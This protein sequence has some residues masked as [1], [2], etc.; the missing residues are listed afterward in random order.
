M[1]MEKLS[2][3]IE[4][5]LDNV[6]PGLTLSIDERV[7]NTL[8]EVEDAFEFSE[9]KYQLIEG[10][11]YDY[12]FNKSSF[13]FKENPVIQPF[14]RKK[15]LGRI[16]PNTYVGTL[17]LEIIEEG[18]GKS[19]PLQ[20]EVR[21]RK[22]DYRSD[23][24]FMLESITEKCTDLLLQSNN[25]ISQTFDIDH[26]TDYSTLYQ[27]YSFLRSVIDSEDFDEA[28]NRIINFPVTSWE[29]NEELID[30][31]RLR[32]IN[33]NQIK[34]ISSLPNRISLPDDYSLY[35]A[36]LTTVPTKIYIREKS[37][38]IDTQENRF[39]KNA[40]ETF[41]HACEDIKSLAEE[42]S[43]LK[44]ESEI[45]ILK[46]EEYLQHSFFRNIGR[47]T[48]LKLNS[49][50]LQRK[51]GYREILRTWLMFDLA[52]KLVWKGGEDVYSAGKKDI[53]NLYEYW[54][55]FVLLDLI[56]K[57][58]RLTETDISELIQPT[59]NGLGLQLKQGL[60]TA[61]S[62]IFNEGTRKLNIEFNYNRTFKKAK[63]YPEAG[64]W[65][66][67]MRPDYTLSIWPAVLN[68]KEA[69]NE[70]IIVH[71]H[72]DA[73]YRVEGLSDFNSSFDLIE[74][75]KEN[76]QGVYK[77]ADL[78]KMHAYKDAIRRTSGAYV[79]YPGG[80]KNEK[81]RGFHEIIPGLGAFAIRPNKENTDTNELERFFQEIIEN[82]V[83][84]ISQ[85]EK[86]S[87]KMYDI[88]NLDQSNEN[89]LRE[90]LPEI[91][92]KE[93][94]SFPDETHVLVGYCSSK[95]KFD[96]YKKV[97]L[98]NFRMNEDLGSLELST[99]VSGAKYLVLRTG[100]ITAKEIFKITSKGPKVFSGD[101][102]TALGYPSK[103]KLKDYYLVF[104]I[105]EIDSEYFKGSV[106][107]FQKLDAYKKLSAEI[108]NPRSLAGEPFTTT[109]SELMSKKLTVAPA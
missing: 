32:K 33:G 47:A 92:G 7:E 43:R 56:T 89:I 29:E 66:V 87:Y 103:I 63:S 71:I 41:L 42:E 48:N 9:A 93:R 101:K 72:F 95:E 78:L 22:I 19:S 55:F 13:F 5:L 69:E 68:K 59:K 37:D 23:Y 1:T 35:T 104:E 99:E 57:T 44:K 86:L 28:L 83:N 98:Y 36:G 62:G 70:E 25:P 10:H 75:K 64:S 85:R 108:R 97:G 94:K 39:I 34:S 84:R 60:R 27:R 88:M 67:E 52:S 106:Y 105:E 91:Y 31:R 81:L 15:Y 107:D 49:P 46:L 82:L 45:T 74:E 11:F 53:A 20:L 79:I 109:L 90:S 26:E 8:F 50:V 73:K 54:I 18:S 21:S 24:R 38:Q 51:E 102:L 3:H 77:N 4:I 30:I 76:R 58:F 2:P 65:S 61:V 14:Q 40:L 100:G 96:W 16:S 17:N 12:E 80:S 6:E